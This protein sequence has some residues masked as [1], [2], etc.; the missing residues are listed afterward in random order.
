MTKYYHVQTQEAYDSLMAFLE[1]LGYSWSA[2]G[3]PTEVNVFN[4]YKEKTVINVDVKEKEL[5]FSDIHYFKHELDVT[6]FIEWTPDL[7]ESV[8]YGVVSTMRQLM[9]VVGILPD[10]IEKLS[11]A[12]EIAT[13]KETMYEILL[14]CLK[15]TD[16]EFQ[17]LSYKNKKWFASRKNTWLKQRFTETELKEK[18]PEFYRELAVKVD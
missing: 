18:V 12:L 9:N 15:T 5:S 14:P 6:E 11:V 10:H 1:A 3:E 16:G 8:Y 17:Y 4:F 13:K 2:D 7:A